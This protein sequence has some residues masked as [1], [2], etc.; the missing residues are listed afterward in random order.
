LGGANAVFGLVLNLNF[1]YDAGRR[2]FDSIGKLMLKRALGLTA[3]DFTTFG[4]AL[5]PSTDFAADIH[6]G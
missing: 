5:S 6:G 4:M 2:K 1:V 3:P